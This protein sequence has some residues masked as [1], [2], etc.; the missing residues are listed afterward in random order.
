[1]A[2]FSPL[3][4]M[5]AEVPAGSQHG[6]HSRSH[7]ASAMRVAAVNPDAQSHAVGY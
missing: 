7:A 5:L 1:M 2:A 4:D 3:L 6:R